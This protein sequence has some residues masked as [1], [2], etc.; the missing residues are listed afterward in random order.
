MWADRI[1][2]DPKWRPCINHGQLNYG[3]LHPKYPLPIVLVGAGVGRPRMARGIQ[4][5]GL[6]DQTWG[7]NVRGGIRGK[8][9]HFLHWPCLP[10]EKGKL[11]DL[12]C[13]YKAKVS[14]WAT[15]QR[16]QLK[17][18]KKSRSTSPNYGTLQRTG[19]YSVFTLHSFC[20]PSFSKGGKEKLLFLKHGWRIEYFPCKHGRSFAN[21]Y[22]D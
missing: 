14:G 20:S 13:V 10:L 4:P 15:V 17:S 5:M 2:N 12:H 6:V 8:S 16:T 22:Y 21:E 1:G 3:I 9:Q 11:C 19:N 18:S 7:C